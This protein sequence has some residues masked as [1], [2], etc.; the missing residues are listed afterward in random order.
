MYESIIVATDGSEIADKAVQHAIALAKDL[1]AN[2][3]AVTVTEPFE[4]VAFTENMTVIN[5]ADYKRQCD[6]YA[7]SILAKVTKSAAANGTACETIHQD[8]H[9]PYAG[10]IDAAEKSHADLIV[11][12]S[13]GRCGL[14]R[15]LPG[16]QAA[17]LLAHTKTATLVM[18]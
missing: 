17:K 16:S 11:M 18:R 14:E 13:H 5:P 10:V 1:D 12:G 7:N 8:N 4:S 15:L 3:T 2:L 6:E 9:W